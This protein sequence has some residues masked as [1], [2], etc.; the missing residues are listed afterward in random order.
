MSLEYEHEQYLHPNSNNGVKTS[1]INISTYHKLGNMYEYAV[2]KLS[3]GHE[4][5]PFLEMSHH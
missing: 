1:K 5:I 2:D 4:I 3:K